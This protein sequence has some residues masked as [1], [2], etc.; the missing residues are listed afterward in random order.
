MEEKGEYKGVLDGLN[1]LPNGVTGETVDFSDIQ[2]QIDAL[3]KE[4]ERLSD[5]EI[6]ARSVLPVLYKMLIE[7][8]KKSGLETPNV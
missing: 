8:A 5:P 6:M 7:S 4:V 3:K 2:S 1:T